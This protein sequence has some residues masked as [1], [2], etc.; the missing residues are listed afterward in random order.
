[1]YKLIENSDA[2]LRLSDGAII[3]NALGNRMWDEYL[4][5][6][7]QGNIPLEADSSGDYYPQTLEEAKRYMQQL[8]IDTASIK[9]EALVEGYSPTEQA[10][11]DYKQRE[12][13][14][15]LESGN[16]EEC[17]YLK[18]EAVAMTGATDEVTIGNVTQQLAYVIVHKADQLRLASSVIAGIRARKWNEVEAMTDIKEIMNYP[19][20]QRWDY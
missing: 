5:W 1:M 8:I 13:A 10:T 6:L 3:P 12:A 11:W 19:V 16:I 15:Y 9:Q 2:I 4:Y 18:A 7:E 14:A 20:D 17:K